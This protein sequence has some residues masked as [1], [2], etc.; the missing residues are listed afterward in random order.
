[1]DSFKDCLKKTL[2]WLKQQQIDVILINPQYGESL[3]KDGY[4]EEVVAAVAAIALPMPGMSI[5]SLSRS[6]AR[7]AECDL[8]GLQSM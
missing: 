6:T 5:L 3:V 4:Y 8:I 7:L 2:A 1:M